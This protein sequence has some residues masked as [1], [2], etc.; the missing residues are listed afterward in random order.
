MG[1]LERA[2]LILAVI[3]FLFKSGAEAS[4]GSIIC[5]FALGGIGLVL[6]RRWAKLRLRSALMAGAIRGRR[7]IVIGTQSELAEFARCDLLVRF[8]LDEVERVVLPRIDPASRPLGP[9]AHAEA[10]LK[11]VRAAGAD[12][13]CSRCRG[14]IR[15]RSNTCSTG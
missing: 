2:I 5:L 10:V 6:W 11:R 7:A 4:R 15:K 14:R 12:E 9:K 1:E 8:G 3:L 13:I